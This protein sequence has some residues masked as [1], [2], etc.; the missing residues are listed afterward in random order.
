MSNRKDS[1]VDEAC[2]PGAPLINGVRATIVTHEQQKPRKAGV[3][4]Y[5]F[6]EEKGPMADS[7]G[8]SA[9]K[10]GIIDQNVA[11]VASGESGSD[12]VPQNLHQNE[13]ALDEQRRARPTANSGI[14]NHT[15]D[16]RSRTDND[17]NN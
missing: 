2:S 11:V 1:S 7:H 5:I 6:E 12:R 17:N 16:T 10:A 8:L 3:V 14:V 13:V 9:E 4:T 15:F